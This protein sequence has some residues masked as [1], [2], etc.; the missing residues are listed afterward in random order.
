MKCGW[1]SLLILVVLGVIS[2]NTNSLSCNSEFLNSVG[3]DGMDQPQMLNMM[4]CKDVSVKCCSFMDELK[5]HKHW[6]SYYK[7]KITR[8]F[9]VLE[10]VYSQIHDPIEYFHQ[11]ATDYGVAPPVEE[12]AEE[13]SAE[14]KKEEGKLKKGRLLSEEAVEEGAEEGDGDKKEEEEG[15]KKD[16]KKKEEKAPNEFVGMVDKEHWERLG[17]ALHLI[18]TIEKPKPMKIGVEIKGFEKDMAK[19]KESF[20]CL[21]CDIRTH[22][23]IAEIDKTLTVQESICEEAVETYKGVTKDKIMGIDKTL[24]IIDDIMD[25]FG[26]KNE[27][28]KKNVDL[29]HKIKRIAKAGEEC[30]SNNSYNFENCKEFCSYH[31][32]IDVSPAFFGDLEFFRG[33]ITRFKIF[34]KFLETEME[35]LEAANP[36]DDKKK[37][38]APAKKNKKKK[39][40]FRILSSANTFLFKKLYKINQSVKTYKKQ[41]NKIKK[42]NKKMVSKILKINKKLNRKLEKRLASEKKRNRKLIRTKIYTDINAE[43][44]FNDYIQESPRRI[45]SWSQKPRSSRRRRPRRRGLGFIKKLFGRNKKQ[46]APK[47]EPQPEPQP[48]QQAEPAPPAPQAQAP[49][50]EPA[51]PVEPEEPKD[52]GEPMKNK[53]D[54]VILNYDAKPIMVDKKGNIISVDPKGEPIK[55]D[56]DGMPIII[57]EDGTTL[58]DGHIVHTDGKVY[59]KGE[60]PMS[61]DETR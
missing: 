17:G 27:K 60:E 57:L 21:A 29:N 39:K 30:L 61:P 20:I 41:M 3:L 25:M 35:A 16:E 10:D 50:P 32:I 22:L 2:Q 36:K 5:F 47:P 26:H 8:I 54:E 56:K 4:M 53:E 1:K 11:L 44:D 38:K 15:D 28:L 43:R 14:E 12:G 51:A 13:E 45:K 31:S 59:K 6:N 55:K 40:K 19:K 34:E 33:V 42:K 46:Q 49:A 18:T 48:E 24:A 52:E 23:S 37:D 9:E 7:I 58:P